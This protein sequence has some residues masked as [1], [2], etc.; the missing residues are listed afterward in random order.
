MSSVSTSQAWGWPYA[1]GK[2]LLS[3]VIRTGSVA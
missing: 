2:W 3:M 1:T